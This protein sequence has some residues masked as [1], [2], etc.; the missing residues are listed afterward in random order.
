M[1]RNEKGCTWSMSPKDTWKTLILVRPQTARPGSLVS[2]SSL[3]SGST[4]IQDWLLALLE[5]TSTRRNWWSTRSAAAPTR[6]GNVLCR[7]A[8]AFLL[9][10][11]PER[12][13]SIGSRRCR[14]RS[15]SANGTEHLAGG[16]LNALWWWPVRDVVQ[17]RAGKGG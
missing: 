9:Q 4:H 1:G 5:S 14:R 11:R 2:L 13:S 8:T 6:K 17:R 16:V 10:R 3:Y 12:K 15:R 7:R